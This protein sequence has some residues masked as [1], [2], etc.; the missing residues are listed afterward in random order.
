MVKKVTS[1]NETKE[2]LVKQINDLNYVEEHNELLK[3]NINSL[4]SSTYYKKL[5]I[6]NTKEKICQSEAKFN[7]IQNILSEKKLCLES[8]NKKKNTLKIMLESKASDLSMTAKA[9]QEKK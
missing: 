8:M 4:K 9:M 5:K 7:A 6:E 1:L 3:Q 2:E